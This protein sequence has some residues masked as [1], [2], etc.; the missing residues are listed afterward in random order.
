MWKLFPW[1]VAGPPGFGVR[2]SPGGLAMEARQTKAPED[3]RSPRRYRAIRSFSVSLNGIKLTGAS[4]EPDLGAPASRRR[5]DEKRVGCGSSFHGPSQA[6]QVLAC[7]SPL[8]L[9]RWRRDK[10]K[11]QRTGAVQDATARFA[12]SV[13]H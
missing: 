10:R 3:W 2:Q 5:G 6:R 4:H 11:R 12:V 9:W 13:C 1:T 8:A 7:A